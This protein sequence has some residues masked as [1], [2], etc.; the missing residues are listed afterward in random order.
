VERT[1]RRGHDALLHAGIP[2]ANI[3]VCAINPHAGEK[4][5]VIK[6]ARVPGAERL[7]LENSRCARHAREKFPP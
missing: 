3:G 7:L 1:I 4:R 5:A 6:L 2:D